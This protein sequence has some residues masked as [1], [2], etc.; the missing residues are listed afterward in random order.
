MEWEEIKKLLEEQAKTYAQFKSA[1]DERLAKLEKGSNDPLAVEKVEK[2]NARVGELQKLVEDAV[3]QA[4][5]PGKSEA[6]REAAAQH[7]KAFK[8]WLR[9]GDT[10]G[11]DELISTKAVTVGTDAEGGYAVPE[12]LQ[13]DIMTLVQAATPMR[14]L[15]TVISGTE[16]WEQVVDL[17]G[18]GS[19]WVAETDPRPETASPTLTRFAPSFGEVY[20]MPKASQKAIEDLGFDVEG[21]LKDAV[22]RKFA[23]DEDVAFIAGNGTNKPLGLLAAPLATTADATR[24]FGTI[25]R[26]NSGTAGDFDGDDLITLI[27]TLRQQYRNGAAFLMPNMTVAHVRRLKDSTGNYVWSPGLQAGQPASIFGYPVREDENLPAMG[28]GA[29]AILFGNFKEAYLVVDVV[30]PMTVLR[31]PFS[32]KPYVLFYCRRRVGGGP[33]NTEAVKVLTLQA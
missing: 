11:L 1:N 10:K 28:A 12:Q 16:R 24:P 8:K 7:R 19:G 22:A 18:V 17:G 20:A 32:N 33:R 13:R 14:D 4:G 5:R 29:N 23:V 15:A 2:L 27:H 21:W 31:D 26:V 3:K 30:T 6:A 9:R 25:Q